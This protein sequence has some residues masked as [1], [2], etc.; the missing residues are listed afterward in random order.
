M[1]HVWHKDY[2]VGIYSIK[3]YNIW[4]EADPWYWFEWCEGF[5]P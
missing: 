3:R 2:Y 1:V 4:A 5:G